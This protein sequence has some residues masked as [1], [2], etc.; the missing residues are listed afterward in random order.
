VQFWKVVVQAKTKARDQMAS[1][2]IKGLQASHFNP[3]VGNASAIDRSAR[4]DP[5][6]TETMQQPRVPLLHN[7]SRARWRGAAHDG[8]LEAATKV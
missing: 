6:H 2:K 1:L 7:A 5:K 4:A 3:H 8:D